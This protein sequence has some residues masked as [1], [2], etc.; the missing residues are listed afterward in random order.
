[1]DYLEFWRE[2]EKHL[3]PE[4]GASNFYRVYYDDHGKVL[5][6][7]MEDRPGN[8]LDID[9]E[10]YERS[11]TRVRVVNGE[12]IPIKTPISSKLVPDQSGQACH[13]ANIIVVTGQEPMQ[14][15]NLRYY[16]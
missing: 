16:D 9:R 4:V 1:M 15:W 2:V 8:Y 7:S 12:L 14:K 13:P 10:T 3:E 11:S 5:F 6:Y